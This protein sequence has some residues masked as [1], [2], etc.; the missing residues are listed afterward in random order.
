LFVVRGNPLDKAGLRVG[1][2]GLCGWGGSYGSLRARDAP[3]PNEPNEERGTAA[4]D[5][6]APN[7]LFP[8]RDRG[9]GPCAL[10]IADS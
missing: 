5:A 9:V 4:R 3:W 1:G 10:L 2:Y 6:T 8:P 7:R